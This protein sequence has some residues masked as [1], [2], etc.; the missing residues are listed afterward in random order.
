[1]FLVFFGNLGSCGDFLGWDA[2]GNPIVTIPDGNGGHVIRDESGNFKPLVPA[3]G[4][5]YRRNEEGDFEFT[6]KR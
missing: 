2:N 1:M 6:P 5:Y 3:E 4:G